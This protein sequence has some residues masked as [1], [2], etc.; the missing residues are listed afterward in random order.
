MNP[1]HDMYCKWSING[2]PVSGTNF[3]GNSTFENFDVVD[4]DII[5]VEVIA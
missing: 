3:T 4:G 1:C 5:K 2:I